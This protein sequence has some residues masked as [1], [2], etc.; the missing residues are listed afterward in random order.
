MRPLTTGDFEGC[1][2]RAQVECV[3]KGTELCIIIS[4]VLRA[5]FSA[6][7]SPERRSKALSRADK[8]LANWFS[9]LPKQL[10]LRSSNRGLWPA[11][12]HVIYNNFLLILHRP[13]PGSIGNTVER[14][15]NE[16]EIC[17]AAASAI[18]AVFEELCEKDLLKYTWISSV[19]AMLTTM[20]QV[21]AELRFSNPVLFHS[22][23]RRF[24]STLY[25][26]R[27]L[28]EYWL[29]ACPIVRLFEERSERIQRDAG[30]MGVYPRQVQRHDPAVPLTGNTHGSE[31]DWEQL[32][33]FMDTD[34][35]PPD[36]FTG[37]NEWRELY[38]QDISLIDLDEDFWTN[39]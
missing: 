37:E 39:P 15:P 18:V 10:H 17:S 22:A 23:L 3:I 11:L 31:Q 16:S 25:S 7:I 28:S 19:N 26:L 20:L 4:T 27:Q 38:W 8:A 35:E 6:R 5:R 2:G 9:L 34:P 32:F 12:L 1:E 21:N 29:S 24:D 14:G 13:E 33:S 36:S 30:A